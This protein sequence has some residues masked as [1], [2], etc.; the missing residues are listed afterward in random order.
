MGINMDIS[1]MPP[2]TIVTE[3]M[4]DPQQGERFMAIEHIIKLNIRIKF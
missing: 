2:D 3:E 4:L 1:K